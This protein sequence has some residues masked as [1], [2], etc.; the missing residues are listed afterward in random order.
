MQHSLQ[1]LLPIAGDD[2]IA[3][4]NKRE[5]FKTAVTVP[6]WFYGLHSSA[7]FP[8]SLVCTTKNLIYIDAMA[9]PKDADA[10]KGNG[11]DPSLPITDVDPQ[12]DSNDLGSDKGDKTNGSKSPDDK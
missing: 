5:G 7:I 2:A 12:D 11:H 10:T 8:Q 3:S 6:Y 4:M 9:D 1:A